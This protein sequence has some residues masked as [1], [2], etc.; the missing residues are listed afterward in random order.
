[1]NLFTL[2]GVMLVGYLL[3]AI[4]FAVIIARRHGVDILKAGS[5]NP[6]ATNVKRVL[7]KTAGNAC[8][9][10]D[11]LKGFIATI[12]PRLLIADESALAFAI[13]GLVGAI[14]GHSF[15]VFI[16]FK[17]GKGVAVTMGGLLALAPLVLLCGLLIWVATFYTSRYVSLASIVFGV[18]LP[19]IA[20]M[21]GS[22]GLLIGFLVLLAALIVLRHRSNIQRL[23][24]GT[25]NRF[26]KKDKPE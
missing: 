18:S 8:F 2:I 20:L 14:L 4:P 11:V 9:A 25:E 6:G 23:I 5:G 7:G 15:S 24:A 16:G 3:G 22:P 26:S 13:L 10:L 17:G 19:L 21:T 1:M 12:L